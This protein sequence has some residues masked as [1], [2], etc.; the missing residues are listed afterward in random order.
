MTREE[1]TQWRRIARFANA[2]DDDNELAARS[3][4]V[5]GAF[6]IVP[7]LGGLPA[8]ADPSV[9]HSLA[10]RAREALP[11]LRALLRG[12]VPGATR[13]QRQHVRRLLR[14]HR[15]HVKGAEG[16]THEAL[17]KGSSIPGKLAYMGDFAAIAELLANKK[18]RMHKSEKVLTYKVRFEGPALGPVKRYPTARYRD[19]LDPIIHHLIPDPPDGFEPVRVCGLAACR[20]FFL[21]SGRRR[22]CSAA[23]KWKYHQMS[24][25]QRRNYQR[26]YRARA[27]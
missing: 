20:K 15:E 2:D 16:Q 14:E 6:G 9:I 13:A 21:R 24:R 1:A 12:L 4:S 10:A 3:L 5:L 25:E 17:L 8:R 27:R 23:C 18:K 11:E 7:A 22:F 26:R 19:L